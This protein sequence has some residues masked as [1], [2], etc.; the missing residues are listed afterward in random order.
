MTY[1]DAAALRMALEQRLRNDAAARRVRIDRLRRQVAFERVMIR[2]D[3]AQPDR[4]VLK[5]GMA[6][7]AR[8]GS[9]ARTTRDLDLGL[10]G[11]SIDGLR[12]R[13]DL[14]DALSTDPDRDHFVFRVGPPTRLATDEAGDP[15]WRFTITSTL[16]G[17]EF[18]SLPVD[19]SPRAHELVTTQRMTL[20]TALD[21]AG[22]DA[23][24]VEIIDVNRH[25][26]EKIHAMT[27]TFSD[28]P[29]TRVRD[30][31]DLVLLI[32]HDLVD[33]PAARA[34]LEAVFGSRPG[35]TVPVTIE[36]PPEFWS[37]RYESL[38]AETDVGAKTLPD[39]LALLR[40]TWATISTTPE[41]F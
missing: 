21:F 20:S 33:A 28:R 40:A 10:R 18:V 36:D 37:E 7:E 13:D 3:L 39:A 41:E 5:G 30:L 19:I 6:L 38:A 25:F 29:N 23:R 35:R 11:P 34:E 9:A 14:I 15:T 26:A 31:V 8:L 2:L 32:E 16:D 27:T 1:A 17:R 22:V 24:T 12:L 4:W